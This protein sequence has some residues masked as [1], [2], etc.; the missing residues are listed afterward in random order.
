V[1]RFH[2]HPTSLAGLFR[3]EPTPLKDSR[4]IF[5]RLFCKNEFRQIGFDRE[6]VHIN[7]S[8]TRRRGT[9]RGMHFQNPPMEEVKIVFCLK[10]GVFDVAVDIRR[11]SP[12]YLN[13][14]SELLYADQGNMLVIPE[15]FAHGFQTL[16]PDS[17]VMYFITQYHSRE[18]QRGFR[19]DDPLVG[20]RWPLAV[21][22]IS[23]KDRQWPSVEELC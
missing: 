1:S 17:T 16:E 14:H 20:I 7:R 6:I 5:E 22:E 2:F 18:D 9:V 13:W 15:G 23:E 3:V 10:G 4:G 12:T 8:W 19:F 11:S 21:A